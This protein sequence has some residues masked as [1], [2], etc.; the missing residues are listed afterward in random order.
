MGQNWRSYYVYIIGNPRGMLYTGVTNDIE[1]RVVE[2]R[3]K[4]KQGYASKFSIHRLLFLE[5]FSEVT[6]AIAAEK[7]IKGWLRAKKIALIRSINPR[8]EDLSK[9]WF[10]E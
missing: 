5:E 9:D 8:F 4:L 6:D 3:K 1:R 2:H 10:D 7:R